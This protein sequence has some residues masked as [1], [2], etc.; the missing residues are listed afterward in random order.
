MD[1]VTDA[2]DAVLDAGRLPRADG[3]DPRGIRTLHLGAGQD[4][5][6]GKP[7]LGA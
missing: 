6:G 2:W 4:Q 5:Q 7:A 1:D 3:S